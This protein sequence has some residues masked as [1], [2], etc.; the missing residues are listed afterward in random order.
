MRTIE[1]IPSYVYVHT[2]GRQ[3]SPHGSAP[4][5]N[6]SDREN[7]RLEQRGWTWKVTD[8]NGVT[9]IGACR[10]PAA[11]RAEAEKVADRMRQH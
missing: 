8:H 10:R 7:W 1:V 3:A 4:W 2:S 11:T 9:T 5:V 6:E